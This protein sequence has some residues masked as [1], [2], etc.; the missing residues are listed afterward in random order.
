MRRRRRRRRKC[1][2]IVRRRFGLKSRMRVAW[3]RWIDEGSAKE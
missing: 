2:Q 1:E 3:T